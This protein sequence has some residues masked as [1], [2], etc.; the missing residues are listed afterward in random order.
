LD[1]LKCMQR[2]NTSEILTAADK[3]IGVPLDVSEAIMKWAPV[4]TGNKDFPE[5]PLIAIKN[6]H[7]VK[8]PFAIG[9]NL[10]D[11][12]LFGYAIANNAPLP[13][14]EYIAIVSGIFH[15]S[16]EAI[17]TVLEQYP[18]DLEGDNKE[19]CSKMLNDYMFLC[20][21]RRTASL[22]YEQG[23]RDLYYYQF[24]R[25]PIFCPWPAHQSFCCNKVCHG[26]ELPYVFH[27]SG[28]PYPWNFTGVDLYISNATANYWA[29]F[30]MYG[31]PNKYNEPGIPMWPLY[32]PKSDQNID[33]NW[34]LKTVTQLNKKLC[35][36]WDSIGYDHISR[37]PEVLKEARK[38]RG[39]VGLKT[40]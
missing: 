2:K 24:T 27:D 21:S 37:V 5:E 31:D 11:G 22:L 20:D 6:G 9:S 19:V 32:D 3:T 8:V 34:P 15:D 13:A 30:A 36:I 4:V 23:F 26:D 1:D 38:R 16:I 14:Y 40:K 25:Q 33:L 18:A 39:L 17:T 7:V 35:D 29:S 10:N 28:V 12:W